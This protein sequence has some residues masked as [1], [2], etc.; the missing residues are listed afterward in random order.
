MQV[1]FASYQMELTKVLKEVEY[2]FD[3]NLQY[4]QKNHKDL[5]N[6][7]DLALRVKTDQ[8]QSNIEKKAG[9]NIDYEGLMNQY[10]IK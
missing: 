9:V 4:Q 5:Q 7:I 3:V 6:I 8:G 10:L 1:L 2:Q